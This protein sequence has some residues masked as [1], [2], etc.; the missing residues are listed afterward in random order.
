MDISRKHVPLS[1]RLR[2][3]ELQTG[4]FR[5]VRA[6]LCSTRA[7]IIPGFTDMYC[8]S[9]LLPSSDAET[10]CHADARADS[11]VHTT[12]WRGRC[13]AP[14]CCHP[15]AAMPAWVTWLTRGVANEHVLIRQMSNA[16]T[17]NNKDRESPGWAG[18]SRERQIQT[19]SHTTIKSHCNKVMERDESEVVNTLSPVGLFV[20]PWTTR[21]LCF[22]GFPRQ[23]HWSGL[24]FPSPG[25]LLTQGSIHHVSWSCRW[26][27]SHC[28][29]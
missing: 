9:A 16:H 14:R 11:C 17:W 21:L 15:A 18:A 29:T 4:H 2:C 26:I 5:S 13:R 24:P 7:V 1:S 19:H 22:L 8:W 6:S 27:L 10:R 3:W 12:R 20:T 23:E 25:G 28:A